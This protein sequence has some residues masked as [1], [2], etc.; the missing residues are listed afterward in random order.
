MKDY[1]FCKDCKY[2]FYKE[3]IFVDVLHCEKRKEK[4]LS[5]YKGEFFKYPECN[6]LNP[7]YDCKLFEREISTLEKIKKF[8]NKIFLDKHIKL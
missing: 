7:D 8:F 2:S 3:Y 4:W 1:H 6:T 5:N